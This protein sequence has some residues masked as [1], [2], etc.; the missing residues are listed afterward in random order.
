[1]KKLILACALLTTFGLSAQTTLIPYGA[2]WKYLDNGSNQGTA[3]RDSLFNDAT[4]LSGPAQ[5]GYGDGD[6][7]TVVSFGPS[8]TNKYT[9]TYFRKMIN[10][11][12]VNWFQEF[13]FSLYRDDGV[14]VYVNGREVYRNNMQAGVS[15]NTRFA[16]SNCSDDGGTAQTGH[17]TLQGSNFVS[18]N[19]YIAVE[20]HQCD[21][22]SSDL[23]FDLQLTAKPAYTGVPVMLFT[24]GTDWKYLDNGTDQGTAWRA[25]AFS[26]ATWASGRSH[27]GYGDNDEATVVSFGP[28]ST[29]KY[30]TTYFRKNFTIANVN[31][32]GSFTFNMYRDDGIIIYV[33]GTEVYRNGLATNPAYNALATTASDDGNTIQTST[34]TLA[35][36]NFVSGNNVIAV[37]IHQDGITSS[38]ISFDLQLIGTPPTPPPP[39]GA[40]VVRG[41]YI[42]NG[43]STSIV[44]HWKT[45]IAID[46]RVTFGLT[47]ATMTNI[48][49]DPAVT[50]DHIITLTGLTPYTKYYYSVGS[51]VG[52]MQSGSDN[53]FLTNPTPGTEGKYTFWVTGD[54]GNNSTN[55]QN[56]LNRYNT[57]M[58][59]DT[60]NGWLLLG[61]NAYSSGTETEFTNS[62]FNIYQG[63][64]MK[65]ATL[66][67]TPGNHDYS[68]G[69]SARQDDH[70]IPYYSI[71]DVPQNGEAGGVASGTE[72][73]YSYNYGNVHFLSLDSYGEE[74]N[75]RLY[76][77][78]GAQVQWIKQ[79]LAANTLPWVVCYWH[80]PP[81]T[82]GS[83]NSDSEGELVS[84]RQNFIRILE[85]YG[86]DLILC[87][88]SHDYERSKLM[89]GHYGNEAS[90]NAATHNLDQSSGKYD[91]TAN[92]CAYLKDSL[93][94]LS[95][96]VYVVSG[97]AGQL[98]GQQAGYP[99][100][101][102]PY[103]N[104]TNGGSL[105]L[106]FNGNRLD[107]KWLCAD[108]V[109]RDQF[110]IFKDGS[111]VTNTTINLGDTVSMGAEWPG[112]YDWSH[113]TETTRDVEAAPTAT[114][115]YYVTDQ[116]SC[117]ADTFHVNVIIPTID[118]SA[119]SFTSLCAGSAFALPFVTTGY[120]RPG[121]I[122]TA[123]LSDASGSFASPVNIGS[124]AATSSSSINVV[125][126]PATPDGN[127]Y[128][129]R[130][131]ANSPGLTGLG[132][133][134]TFAISNA[135]PA[136]ALGDDDADNI[137][138]AGNAVNF[139]ASG[140]S[141][142]EFFVN[143]ISQGAP[144]AVNTFSTSSLT[145]G[146]QVN[147]IGTNAC[148]STP[149]SPV[150][151]TVNPL[152][153]ATLS[154]SD[155]DNTIC[156]GTNVTFTGS[157][158]NT[159]EFFVNSV[160]QG[161][162]SA[163]TTFATS[164]LLNGDQVRVDVTN[165]CGTDPASVTMTVNAL[166]SAPVAGDQSACFNSTI[167][168]LNATGSNIVWYSN[169][170]LTTQVGT[171]NSFS[172]GNTASGSYTYY[173]TQTDGN[174]CTGPADAATLVIN[175]LPAAPVAGDEAV[176]FNA[177]VP[178]LSASG[179]NIV[180]YSNSSLTTQVATG[181]VYNTGNS[182]AGTYTY[183]LT[184]TD[185]NGCT[186]AADNA[187][188]TIYALPAAPV[189]VDEAAC[190]NSVIP[191]LTASGTNITWYSNSALTTQVGTGSSLAT[192][193]TAVGSYT[194]YA[195]QTDVNGCVSASD[196][197]TLVINALPAAPVTSNQSSCFNASVPSLNATG[198]GITWYSD[199]NLTA[200]VGSGNTFSS[201]N[202][203]PGTYTYY[204]TQT[205]ANGCSGPA[206]QAD[207]VIFAL[208]VSPSTVSGAACANT[209]IPALNASGTSIRWY[210]DVNLTTQVAAGTTFNTGNTTPGL[211]TYYA[212]ETDANG[213]QSTGA[214]TT[215][216]I[217]TVPTAPSGGN[218]AVCVYASI[219]SLTVA[220]SNVIWY[221]DAGL[222]TQV[223]TG[224]AF[225][226]GNTAPGV[227]TYYST[228]TSVEGCVSPSAMLTL[229]IIA[230]PTMPVVTGNTTYCEGDAM[231]TLIATGSAVIWYANAAPSVIIGT[232]STYFP[233]T[234]VSDTVYVTQTQNGCAS[235]PTSVAI[236][237]NPLPVV[238]ITG[239]L[240]QYAVTD[241]VVTLTGAPAGGTFNGPG[242][243]GNQFDPAVAGIGGPYTITYTYTDPAT[244]CINST[245][246]DVTVNVA[247]GVAQ[248]VSG[249]TISAY[250]NPAD[251]QAFVHVTL[252]NDQ[253]VM[254][255]L[256][257][258]SGQAVMVRD[259]GTMH[260]GM[261]ELVI[262]RAE[263]Q[264]AAGVYSL[265]VQCGD[266]LTEIKI[267]F[268]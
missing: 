182:A 252:V 253:P 196:A 56:C 123:Q 142:Y 235:N 26:D 78:L 99:H 195:T 21:L 191:S 141:T 231:Q 156:Q 260:A 204:A 150:T 144:S 210:N 67:P 40:V 213:C 20:I 88:H 17:V 207:L 106:E 256:Y 50:M 257:D 44:L 193:N 160:S 42:Q 111:K 39:G 173:A 125:I 131:V 18:G 177:P 127:G 170:S 254:I 250:P 165:G 187:T 186:G 38:D 108:G 174:G 205:D 153:V 237:I 9:T 222:T 110:T 232:G 203:A 238:T 120:F 130:I 55:Q 121:N 243:S 62:F 230:Q 74:A 199:V 242:V 25:P 66:W 246:T 138:C 10:I 168:S 190:F 91:G 200:Q 139:T 61:D 201:G 225:N 89:K 34:L 51:T 215:L 223:A 54:C 239:L 93:H 57:Y 198:T 19:N 264:L 211:Y 95:G 8:S 149:S 152:P 126:P 68:N 212:T 188:L 135:A 6:E 70:N 244:G 14:I 80:H 258:L 107:V 194:Y 267:V 5:L 47:P 117:I 209:S 206:A 157:G 255:E 73:F 234:S 85:R 202:T 261:N 185:A 236:V 16:A 220:G 53:Y 76:D 29:N 79:D 175:A 28:S 90:F 45:D 148:G 59:N 23:S 180:W 65:H 218:P 247:T 241:P 13:T 22:T 163:T 192:G 266:E 158:G 164:S 101:A 94:T 181:N 12:N 30:V 248:T 259:C 31:D 97:S 214:V 171:G 178:S 43:T 140:A 176:C 105:V 96:T 119:T 184:Q 229:T 169:A 224:N 41:P 208:P 113:S 128:R 48:V 71:F 137:I 189:G 52:I 1:M 167:P 172:T 197:V 92:S 217:H 118:A 112:S 35:A 122:F 37:E 109:I 86:V 146:Q 64:I 75:M 46:S 98:G 132:E 82:M 155:L 233:T 245:T 183:Y 228:Q 103:S 219:P 4:W 134:N 159:Y 143:G 124:V 49:S 63:S 27:F 265:R 116:Y 162:A 84:M 147:V 227:Y 133:V 81:Y 60:T 32:F 114:T 2:T 154:S 58:T 36:S 15:S 83:H 72:C 240:S 268:N 251:V 102:M 100:N 226:T 115:T 69:S 33:N 166:P 77:T 263:Y 179:T 262:D 87:G 151:F 161:A 249:N 136:M 129:I 3:W 24:F 7:S 145:N 104:A 221:S 11:P 216:T